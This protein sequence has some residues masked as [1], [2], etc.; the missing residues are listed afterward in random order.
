VAKD[1]TETSPV[2]AGFSVPKK[3]FRKAVHRNRV[4]R[5]LREAWRLNKSE[6]YATVPATMQLHLFLVFNGE[7]IPDYNMVNE[8][9]VKGIQKLK[10]LLAA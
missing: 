9:M 7:E 4:R 8:A 2:R 1:E 6:L 10:E 5:L 3:K